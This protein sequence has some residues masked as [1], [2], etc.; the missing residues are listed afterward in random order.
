MTTRQVQPEPV[1]GQLP[2]R[3]RG[4]E[5]HRRVPGWDALEQVRQMRTRLDCLTAGLV[6][7]AR[8]LQVTWSGIRP[9]LSV[10]E[11][12]APHRYTDDCIV[13]RL[14]QVGHLPSVPASLRALYEEPARHIAG[15]PADMS[16]E[17]PD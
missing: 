2:V 3:R 14:K 9:A 1:F 16:E 15:G 11:D 8:L 10:S 12:T 5:A 6:G 17:I 4:A 13:R 7:R